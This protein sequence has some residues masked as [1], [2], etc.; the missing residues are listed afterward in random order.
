MTPKTKK[1]IA[2]EVF[3]VALC[4]LGAFYLRSMTTF[5]SGVD[6]NLWTIKLSGILFIAYYVVHFI[7][8]VFKFVIGIIFAVIVTAVAVIF[9][10]NAYGGHKLVPNVKEQV[11]DVSASHAQGKPR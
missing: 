10:A 8:W 11:Y 2:R 5:K 1:L 3:V 9:I 4:V 7:I 6:Q